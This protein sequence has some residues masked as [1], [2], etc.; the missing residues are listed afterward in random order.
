MGVPPLDDPEVIA[1]SARIGLPVRVA[2]LLLL[3]G[4]AHDPKMR[5]AIGGGVALTDAGWRRMTDDLDVFARPVSAKRLVRALAKMGAR[6]FWI[7]DAHAV[8]YLD[9]DNAEELARGDAPSVRVDVLSTL[10]EPE[11]SAIRT[12]VPPR[13]LGVP[14][15]VFRIDHLAAIKFLAARPQDLVD[16]DH[17][18]SLGVDLD[19]VRYLIADVDEAQVAPMMSRVRKARAVRGVRET[20][21]PFLDDAALQRA[22]AAAHPVRPSSPAT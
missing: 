19:K 14:M 7:T 12:A 9:D 16:F 3:V 8:A 20:P 6:T 22:W 18:V 21:G 15:P 10:T 1:C 11:A 17:L 5:A 2:R 4:R 13:V